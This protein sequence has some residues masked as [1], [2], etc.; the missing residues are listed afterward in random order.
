MNEV[1][2]YLNLIDTVGEYHIMSKKFYEKRG[3]PALSI[4]YKA[5]SYF[6]WQQLYYLRQLTINAFS[7]CQS[8]WLGIQK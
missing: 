1:G 4:P 2:Y 6:M 5:T 7:S 8:D 3:I